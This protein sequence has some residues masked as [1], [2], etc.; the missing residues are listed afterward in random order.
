MEDL[1]RSLEKKL[2]EFPRHSFSFTPTPCHLLRNISREFGVEVYCKRED[3]TGFGFGGNK[4]RKLEF[5]I[6]KALKEGLNA[7]VTSGGIQSNFCRMVAAAGASVGIKVFLVLG[8]IIPKKKTANLLLDELLGAEIHFVDSPEWD[9]WERESKRL[10]QRLS[11][12]GFKIL[13]LP[14]GGS[15]PLGVLGYVWTFLEILRDEM[16]L[17]INFD[18]IVHASGSGGTQAGLVTGKSLTCW[19]GDIIGVSVAMKQ[20]ELK[21]KVLSLSSQTAFLLDGSVDPDSIHINDEFIGKGYAIQTEEAVDAIETFARREGIFL[22]N[23]YTGKAAAALL[24]WLSEGRFE[25]K[26]VLFIHTGGQ[27]ELFSH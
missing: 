19:K 17:N 7:V 21:Q 4:S 15:I 25:G 23:V 24:K 27:V 26:K 11:Q 1:I 8:G 9:I 18:Y 2:E 12:K 5:L 22:D 3:M 16:K 10:A 6:G 13:Y 14:I 20:E